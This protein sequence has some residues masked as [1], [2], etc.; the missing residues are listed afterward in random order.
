VVEHIESAENMADGGEHEVTQ[1]HHIDYGEFCQLFPVRVQRMKDLAERMQTERTSS[2]ELECRFRGSLDR[3]RDWIKKV[4]EMCESVDNLS[5]KCIERSDIGKE[6]ALALKKEFNKLDDC[7][8]NPPGPLD[9]TEFQLL[10]QKK[11]KEHERAEHHHH[12]YT[13]QE[14][15]GF[16][17]F[18]QD[19]AI[20]DGWHGLLAGDQRSLKHALNTT[21]KVTNSVD[22]F[23]AH[24]AAES[25]VQ[26]IKVV[27]RKARTQLDEYEAFIDGMSAPE[28]GIMG[29]SGGAQLSG[30][31]LRARHGE[32]DDDDVLNAV[33]EGDDTSGNPIMKFIQD[34]TQRLT[35]R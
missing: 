15:L 17:S 13:E 18:L 11:K 22:Q 25:V 2:E 29:S 10:L 8:K 16:D 24:D 12:H 6:A 9:S 30:R 19:M 34:C 31:G 32:A 28:V 1:D 23:K 21:N 27:V 3:V 20:T 14:M 7:L 26:K 33:V 4:D 35:S 5:G